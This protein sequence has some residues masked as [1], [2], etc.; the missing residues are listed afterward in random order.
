VCLSFVWG[1]EETVKCWCVVQVGRQAVAGCNPFTIQLADEKFLS[2]TKVTDDHLKGSLLS[3]TPI[4][5]RVKAV[6]IK[7]SEETSATL[8]SLTLCK[9]PCLELGESSSHTMY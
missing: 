5:T 4:I 1:R 8:N 6:T 2:I 7:T 3:F 9:S